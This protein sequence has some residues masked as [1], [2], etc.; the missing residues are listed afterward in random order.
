MSTADTNKSENFPP[1]PKEPDPYECCGRG[2]DPCIFD[3]YA[4]ALARW[5]RKVAEL[6]QIE[7][8]K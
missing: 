8:D 4:K 5:E 7:T 1:R 3:Y 2:C 6:K